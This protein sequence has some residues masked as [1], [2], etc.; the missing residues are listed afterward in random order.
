M[1]P[2][3]IF[4]EKKECGCKYTTYA[5]QV[6]ECSGQVEPESGTGNRSKEKGIKMT[7]A[8]LAV[9]KAASARCDRE[10][11][12]ATFQIYSLRGISF[13]I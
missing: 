9:Q 10:L 3:V 6:L 13:E 7:Q 11:S 1:Y 2:N 5:R 12:Q 4:R 8:C